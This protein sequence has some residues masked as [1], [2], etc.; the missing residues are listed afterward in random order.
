VTFSVYVGCCVL[1]RSPAVA[2]SP[3][4]GTAFPA[5]LDNAPSLFD[6]PGGVP[7]GWDG[8]LFRN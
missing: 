1:F 8:V 6:V 7:W 4:R 5:L 2:A 3:H